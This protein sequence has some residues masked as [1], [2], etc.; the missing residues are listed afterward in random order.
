MILNSDRVAVNLSH[1]LLSTI[2]LKVITSIQII[3]LIEHVDSMKFLL[4]NSRIY[5]EGE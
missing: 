5:L 1:I 4:E 2:E 3:T